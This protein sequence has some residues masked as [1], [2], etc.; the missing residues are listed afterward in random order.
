[1]GNSQLVNL[2]L[3]KH[4]KKAILTPLFRVQAWR[5][6]LTLLT[7]QNWPPYFHSRR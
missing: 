5:L 7:S 6:P 2:M 4:P 1:V 3:R